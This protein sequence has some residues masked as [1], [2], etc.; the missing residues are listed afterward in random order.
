MEEQDVLRHLLEVEAEATALVD[1][2]QAEADH[3]IAEGEKHN[4]ARFEEQHSRLITELEQRSAQALTRLKEDA[5]RELD[6]YRAGLEILPL[7]LGAFGRT[8]DG[9]LRGKR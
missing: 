5:Q 4:R 8:V 6:A 7:D 3:R 2:A 1:D 9:F